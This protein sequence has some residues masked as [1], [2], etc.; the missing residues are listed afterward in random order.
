MAVGLTDR[1]EGT[2]YS[3]EKFTLVLHHI[4]KPA[5]LVSSSLQSCHVEGTTLEAAEG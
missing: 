4:Y 1:H 5:L 2:D 3:S